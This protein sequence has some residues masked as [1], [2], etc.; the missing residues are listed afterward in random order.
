M[1]PTR[2]F[3]VAAALPRTTAAEIQR[4]IVLFT[5]GLALPAVVHWIPASVPLGPILMPLMVPVAL[6]AFLLPLRSALA[7]ALLMPFL[8]M[9][10]TGM[11]PLPIAVGL[12]V[13]GLAFVAVAQ[14]GALVLKQWWAVYLLGALASRLAAWIF[15]AGLTKLDAVSAGWSTLQGTVGLALC[16]MLLPALFRVLGTPEPG[17]ER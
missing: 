4:G 5:V 8:S 7:V 9:S 10:T 6:A 12:A 3:A 1:G 2:S 16:G 15:M 11:P 13:E 14:K 17:S